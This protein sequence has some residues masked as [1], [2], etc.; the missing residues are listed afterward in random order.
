MDSI[1]WQDLFEALVKRGYTGTQNE[2][3]HLY[4]ENSEASNW[5]M[6]H[7][8]WEDFLPASQVAFLE[9]TRV[10]LDKHFARSTVSSLFDFEPQKSRLF[11]STKRID[12]PGLRIDAVSIQSEPGNLCFT[13]KVRGQWRKAK[14]FYFTEPV[15]HAA[16]KSQGR[17]PEG[18]FAGRGP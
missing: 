17:K 3:E 7:D 12:E 10:L 14:D 15:R 1:A 11:F 18:C 8:R 4:R 16:N 2:L 5:R 13:V 6:Y 9:R